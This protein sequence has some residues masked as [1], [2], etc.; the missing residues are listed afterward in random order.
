MLT[1][2]RQKVDGLT[3]AV[4]AILACA[5]GALAL[6][7]PQAVP[8]AFL[9]LAGLAVI[10]L[11][12]IRWEITL[13]AWLWV[14]SYG[15][16]D[17]PQWRFKPPG[18]FVLSGPR[19]VFLAGITAFGIYF[20]R[21]NRRIRIDRALLWAI[22]LTIGYFSAS[23]TVMGW[24]AS[25][26]V[27]TAPYFRFFSGI[28]FPFTMFILVYNSIHDEKQI[29]RILIFLSAY[30][31]YALYI[32][33]LQ[34]MDI[35]GVE[36]AR[37]LIFPAFIND[38]NWGI[39][40]DRARG[41][42][43]ASNWQASLLVLAFYADLFFIRRT[44]GALRASLIVQAV[45][46][47]PAIFFAGVRSGYLAFL[48]CGIVWCLWGSRWRLGRIKLAVGLLGVLL[49]VAVFWSSLTQT[50]RATGGVT[51]MG[52]IRSRQVLLLR[53]WDLIQRRPFFGVGWG[54]YLRAD[55]AIS[56][57]PGVRKSMPGIVAPIQT[58]GN[59]FVVVFTE[60]GV[61]GLTLLVGVF[62][63]LWRQSVFLYR[64]LPRTANSMLCPAFV[65]LFWV[66]LVNYLT[67]AS[68]VDPLWEPFG[69]GLF[70]AMAGLLV[71]FNRLLEPA[72]PDLDVSSLTG[73]G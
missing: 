4:P 69:N 19:V 23:A 18:F 24:V 7:A 35:L 3:L 36:W 65:V 26:P 68:F 50:I 64:R 40:F 25:G 34:Y 59:L 1:I 33:Y 6:V 17:W 45:L 28:L 60:T 16:L 47:P 22:V 62:V 72:K 29:R 39:H 46:I 63:L 61:V 14:F 67:D 42:F 51:Q 52:P 12:A 66:A 71:G 21:Q 13:W 30:T 44:R 57:D 55:L 70:W 8:W 48:L 32:G 27:S 54:Q 37:S 43:P 11:W 56:R 38:P 49:G 10:L 73:V 41:A 53:A 5:A 20:L 9:L 58:P 15:L 2:G 31:W